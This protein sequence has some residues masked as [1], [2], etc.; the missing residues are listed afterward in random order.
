MLAH[1]MQG[2]LTIIGAGRVGRALGKR[3]REHGWKI[4]SVVNQSEASAR[5]AVRFIGMGR[6]SS[7]IGSSCFA[8]HAILLSVPDSALQHVS[9]NLAQYGAADLRGKAVLHTSGALGS[10]VLKALKDCGAYVGSMH[11]LQTF[12][13]VGVPSLEGRI[14]AIEGD[15]GALRVARQM[16]R[17]MGGLAVQIEVSAKAT[18]HAAAALAAGHMLAVEEA[19]TRVLMSI[20]MKRR[21]ALRGLLPLTRQVLENF[22]RVGP[23]SAWTGPLARG[24]Y[25]VVEAHLE[26]LRKFP[27]E[28]SAAYEALNRL[29]ARVLAADPEKLLAVLEKLHS[30]AAAKTVGG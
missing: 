28:C 2:S 4:G 20:G 14:F 16:V 24:D 13:G 6:A 7:A 15:K 29:A 17:A 19:A 27:E 22:E 11:P 25:S 8:A 30:R 1:G 12:T 3:L 21:E 18:Y 10:G 9:Q 26:A 23:R 5:R